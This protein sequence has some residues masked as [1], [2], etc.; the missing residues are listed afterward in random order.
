MNRREYL[1]CATTTGIIGI[2]GCLDEASEVTENA[3]GE[4][5]DFGEVVNHRGVEVAPIRWLTTDEITFD[6]DQG[7]AQDRTPA[8]GAEFLL[9]HIRAANEGDNRRELP[10]RSSAFGGS[11]GR[12]IRVYYS[13]EET[14]TIQFED[15]S[16]T[17]EVDGVQ[18]T[19][20]HRSR[21]E[22]DATGEV[23]PGTTV[24]GWIVAEIAKGFSIEETTIEIEWGDGDKLEVFEWVYSAGAEVSPEEVN[25]NE[26]TTTEI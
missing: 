4:D 15:I 19:P 25:E 22:G 5:R 6:V 16:S 21:F 10:S 18:L 9:T 8:A 26:G 14:N 2:A 17:Y 7:M 11:S 3:V 1:T 13:D 20:Y 23:Y 12:N 24:E